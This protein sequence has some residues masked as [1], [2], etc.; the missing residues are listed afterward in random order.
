MGILVS[1]ICC[2]RI[3]KTTPKKTQ[4]YNNA[5]D[6]DSMELIHSIKIRKIDIAE[7]V[8]GD[9]IYSYLKNDIKEESIYYS[10]DIVESNRDLIF[11]DEFFKKVE[12]DEFSLFSD[13]INE[14]KCYCISISKNTVDSEFSVLYWFQKINGSIYFIGMTCVG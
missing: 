4:Y 3:I 11:N 1:F 6:V 10:K 2:K 5:L 9:C 7:K 8:F 13:Y 12:Y 14:Q